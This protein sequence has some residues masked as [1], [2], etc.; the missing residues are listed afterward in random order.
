[1]LEIEMDTTAVEKRLQNMVAAIAN[2]ATETMPAELLAWQKDDMRRDF[3]NV[4][5]TGWSALTKIWPRSRLSMI[6]RTRKRVER[7]RALRGLRPILR[8]EMF[9]ALRDR[10]RKMLTD[11]LTWTKTGE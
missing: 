7:P 2:T 5:V 8:T 11:H 10:M 6:P 4:E 3:P 1:M 9:E